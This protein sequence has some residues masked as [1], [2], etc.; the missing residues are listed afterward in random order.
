MFH[1]FVITY[2]DDLNPDFCC[3]LQ[4]K[5]KFLGRT[6]G[7]IQYSTLDVGPTIIDTQDQGFIISEIGYTNDCIK[8]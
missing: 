1:I 6:I 7:T 4:K 2:L 5:I 3:A 8:R